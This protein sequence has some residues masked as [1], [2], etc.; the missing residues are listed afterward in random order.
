MEP[1][2]FK[3]QNVVFAENQKEYKPLPAYVD[4]GSDGYT[5]SCWKLSLR[6]RIKLL[7]TGRIWIGQLTFHKPLQ[8]QLPGVDKCTFFL[9][10]TIAERSAK[11]KI[12]IDKLID[13]LAK[14]LKIPEILEAI[15]KHIK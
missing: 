1:I 4:P 3:E 12:A 7:C 10:D 14:S 2:K 6:E 15:N 5:V 11:I 8:P 13:D 9:P